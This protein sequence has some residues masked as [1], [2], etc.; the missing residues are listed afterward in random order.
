MTLHL[1]FN[2]L[3]VDV[4]RDESTLLYFPFFLKDV[5][6]GKYILLTEVTNLRLVASSHFHLQLA[7]SRCW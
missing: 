1:L 3:F 4:A 5:R 6:C 7:L 2:I